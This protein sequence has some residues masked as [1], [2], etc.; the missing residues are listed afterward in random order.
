MDLCF[1]SSAMEDAANSSRLLDKLY[2]ADAMMIKQRLG[3][4]AS[5]ENLAVLRSIPTLY[6]TAASNG[7]SFTIKVSQNRLMHFQAATDPPSSKK[8]NIDLRSIT[9]IRIFSFD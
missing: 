2:G 6:L 8:S 9:A 1:A 7:R 3:E 4:L 5:A